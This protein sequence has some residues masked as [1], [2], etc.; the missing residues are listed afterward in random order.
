MLKYQNLSRVTKSFYGVKFEPGSIHDV[1]GY[2]NDKRFRR[3]REDEAKQITAA[4]PVA[5][6]KPVDSVTSESKRSPKREVETETT[7]NKKEDNVNG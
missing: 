6:S 4:K 5:K 3:L 1:P 2:I 7:T